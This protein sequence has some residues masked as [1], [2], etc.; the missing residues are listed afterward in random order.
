[1][2]ALK[3]WWAL[4]YERCTEH[5]TIFVR[6]NVTLKWVPSHVGVSGDQKADRLAREE[7]ERE[8]TDNQISYFEKNRVVTLLKELSVM[9]MMTATAYTGRDH[10]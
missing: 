6:K 4:K 1:M 8:Q 10:A 2:Q 5:D 7:R 3:E 9:Q